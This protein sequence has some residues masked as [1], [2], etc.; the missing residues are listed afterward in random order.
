MY[1]WGEVQ[2]TTRLVL[3]KK[4]AHSI[5]KKKGSEILYQTL[6]VTHII[7]IYR[8]TVFECIS[9]FME[10]PTYCQS[11]ISINELV[12]GMGFVTHLNLASASAFAV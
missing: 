11:N 7:H 10:I 6:E 12:V 9:E 2:D 1:N 8:L 3:L 5:F 4:T